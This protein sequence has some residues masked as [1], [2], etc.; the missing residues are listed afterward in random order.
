[1]A[2]IKVNDNIT[3]EVTI[4]GNDLYQNDRAGI[5]IAN[6]CNLVINR[7][8]IHD[9][10]RGGIHTGT[11]VADDYFGDADSDCTAFEEPYPCCTGL[12][13][14]TCYSP[15]G[16]IGPADSAFLD[17]SQ[18]KVYE[19][20]SSGYGGG[21]DIR[22]ASGSIYNNLIY[23]NRKC[24]IRF[25][26]YIDEIVNNTVVDNGHVVNEEDETDCTSEGVPYSCCIGPGEW[27][28]TSNNY[29]CTDVDVPYPCCT[30]FE[31]GT[32]TSLGF[33]GGI[34]YDDLTGA[35]NDP[36]GGYPLFSIPIRNNIA[37]YNVKAGI[38]VRMPD[39]AC[40]TTGTYWDY[41]LLF[42]NN[43]TPID[44]SPI[45]SWPP[46]K[47]RRQLGGCPGNTNEIFALPLFED[48]GNDDYRILFTDFP[49]SENDSPAVDAG[50]Y[51]YGDDVSVPPGVGAIDID[52]G[53]YGG[54]YGIDW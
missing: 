12:D 36:T 37:A 25:G 35:V 40:D 31:T 5:C 41:N 17:V 14:G 49:L 21:V 43:G 4:A 10:I 27:T 50:D 52:M 8:D 18:N 9:N 20:G 28:C 42:G 2:G 51:T 30:G 44:V 7:N 48:R 45:P 24:G 3:G 39:N 26:D 53:A 47:I 22:H 16:F 46:W 23:E 33:G 1:M 11:D 54:P 13:T 15:E 38:R 32:C 34:I 6:G 29:L 19:N